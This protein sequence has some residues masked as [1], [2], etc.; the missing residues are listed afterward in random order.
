[1]TTVA[2]VTYSFNNVSR[3]VGPLEQEPAESFARELARK[4][5]TRDVVLEEWGLINAKKVERP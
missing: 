2:F 3:R 4:E 5:G 1:M